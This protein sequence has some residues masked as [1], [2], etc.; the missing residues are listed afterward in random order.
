MNVQVNVQVHV[1]SCEQQF[2]CCIYKLSLPRSNC[3][4]ECVC[5]TRS[6]TRFIW[7]CLSLCVCHCDVTCFS[8]YL[9]VQWITLMYTRVLSSLSC[10]LSAM[11]STCQ[12]MRRGVPIKSAIRMSSVE[13][14]D[15][16][17]KSSASPSPCP[18]PV[19][20]FVFDLLLS[21]L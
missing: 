19:S 17:E 16:N 13:I 12:E 2:E 5:D 15:T 4:S 3:V 18:S 9:L 21:S 6:V 8:K 20:V 10:L 1:A 11:P 14:P 7:S